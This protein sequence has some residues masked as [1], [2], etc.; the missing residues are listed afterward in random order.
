MVRYGKRRTYVGAAVLAA[1]SMLPLALIPT[2]AAAG[3]AYLGLYVGG[4]IVDA[5][6]SV[7]SQEAVTAGWRSTMAGV[8]LTAEG[9]S[10]TLVGFA[11]G[12]AIVAFGYRTMFLIVAAIASAAGAV[13][14]AY[15]RK[16]RG[17]AVESV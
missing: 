16:P 14:W 6:Y 8:T 12:M 2:W 13:F 17:L 4:M 1:G 5:A 11:G 7:F 15:F 3:L 9:I 10:R